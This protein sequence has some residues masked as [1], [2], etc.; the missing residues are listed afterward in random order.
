MEYPEFSSHTRKKTLDRLAQS[1]G[2]VYDAII[3]GGG[4]VGAGLARE[5]AIRGIK[6]LLV[7][8]RDFASGTSS[9]SSK[10]IHGGLRYL[11]MFDFGLVF[12]ALAERH[13]LLKTHPHLVQPLQFN[14]PIYSKENAPEGVRSSLLLGLGLWVYDALSLFRTPFF[15]GRY[16]TQDVKQLFPGIREEGLKGSYYYADAMMMDDEVVLETVADAHR[17]GAT[18][19]NYVEA[20]GVGPRTAEGTFE[21]RL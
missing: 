6:S 18:L 12:E 10:L 8:K 21:V 7:E 16:K 3:I 13:W 2:E 4:I 9:K 15:H 14:L 5:L 1:E 20:L 17:R 19:F 11:E